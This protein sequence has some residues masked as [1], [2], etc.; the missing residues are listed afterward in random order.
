MSS[1]SYD[2]D[3]TNLRCPVQKIVGV[4][5]FK[6][7]PFHRNKTHT[8]P[9]HLLHLMTSGSRILR[10]AGKTCTVKAGDLI[11]YYEA[12]E[13]E[14]IGDETEVTFLSVGFLATGF[15]PLP[16]AAVVTHA[17][18]HV[19][20]QFQALYKAFTSR[21]TTASPFLV[22]SILMNIL[23]SIDQLRTEKRKDF[24]G[25]EEFWWALEREL[26]KRRLFRPSLDDLCGLS[27]YSKASI[28]RSCRRATGTTPHRRIRQLRMEEARGLLNCS[29]FNITQVA[30]HLGYPRMHEF[31]REFRAFYGS[32]PSANLQ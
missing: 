7:P 30:Q 12:E 26:R 4:W 25:A 15:Q 21:K 31:S 6:F 2:F 27:G 3:L 32:P 17:D 11:Y 24:E 23:H 9:G 13:T 5:E 19:Q 14:Y 8:L 16:A 20:E 29:N 28:L 1:T 10:M 18:P 22:Y